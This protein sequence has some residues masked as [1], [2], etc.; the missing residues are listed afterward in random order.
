VPEAPAGTVTF[1]FSD[2]EGSTRLWEAHPDAMRPALSEH[3]TILRA[4]VEQHNGYVVK[5]TGDGVHAAFGTANAGVLAAIEAQRALME[6]VWGEETGP[7]RVRMGLHSGEAELRDGDYYGTAVN[8]AARIMGVAHGG[9]IVCSGA[10]EGLVR[11][12]LPPGVELVDLGEHRLRDLARAEHLFQIRAPGLPFEFPPLQSL[13]AF[14]GNLP[15][16]LTSFVGRDDDLDGVSSVLDDARLV[17]LTGVGGVGKTRLALEI[18]A[19]ALPQVPDGAWWCELAPAG[20]EEA[21]TQVVAAGLGISAQPGLSLEASIIELLRTRD[22]LIV[23]DNCEHLLDEAGRFVTTILHECRS[24]RILATSR[25]AL[26]VDGERVWPLRSLGVPDPGSDLDAVEGSDAVR[27]FVERVRAVRPGFQLDAN[28]AASVTEVCRRLDGIPLALELAAA[29]AASMNPAEIAG[30]LDERFRLLTGGRRQG[31]ER[32]RTLRATI[33]WSFSLL[34]PVEQAIFARLSVFAGSFDAEGAGA[35]VTGEGVETWDALDAI[36]SLVAKSMIGTDE[37]TG[38]VTRYRMLET[39]RQYGEDRLEEL[40]EADAWR[41]RLAEHFARFAED[42]G[43]ALRGP[44][45]PTWRARLHAE[46]DNLRAAV[47]WALDRDG[48]DAELGVRIVAGLTWEANT[49]DLLG[50]TAWAERAIDAARRSTPGRRTDVLAAA[51]WASLNRGDVQEALARVREALDEGSPAD[52]SA[53][54]SPYVLLGYAQVISGDLDAAIAATDEGLR[55]LAAT[56]RDGLEDRVVLTT[57]A[58]GWRFFAGDVEAARAEAL[59]SVALARELGAASPLSMALFLSVVTFWRDDPERARPQLEEAI[60]LVESGAASRPMYPLMLAIESRLCLMSGDGHG[61]Y[62]ALRAAVVEIRRKADQ[63][64]LATTLGYAIPV[65]RDLGA[66]ET[67]AMM[68]G[69]AYD[70]PLAFLRN[71]PP[72]EDRGARDV[73]DAVRVELGDEVYEAAAARGA[74]MSSDQISDCLLAEL[75][76]QLATAPA[77]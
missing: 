71:V 40:S 21:L 31:V 49:G 6:H 7:L 35:V 25:E 54:A 72:P 9:Q 61:A 77:P 62:A 44:E 43:E 53:L 1:L 63:P 10:T 57:G 56:G 50:I 16:Q 46:L 22:A 39:L 69:A 30:H 28:D 19:S 36:A 67:V 76:R 58:A 24:V 15:G 41:R 48:D 45:E 74:A 3:D 52:A 37:A 55:V 32:H 65:V 73:L 23:L 27:L 4:A 34:T 38:G 42:A 59:E 13:D 68:G 20:D 64:M 75:D 11:D 33:D 14:P 66:N 17:T 8:R 26:A 12:D 2:L 29:R 60:E 5:T 18:A 51:S 70:G 47:T